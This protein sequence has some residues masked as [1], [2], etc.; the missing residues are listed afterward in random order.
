LVIA[1]GGVKMHELR[2]SEMTLPDY[3]AKGNLVQDWDLTMKHGEV[4]GRAVPIGALM[5]ALSNA[6]L[7]RQVIDRT[8]LTGEYNFDLTWTPEDE[9]DAQPKGDLGLAEGAR[10]SIF[11]AVQ[12][13]LGLRLEPTRA[14]VDAL[15]IEHIERPTN[16]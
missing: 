12:E 11:T 1:K 7:D 10:L 6:S 14:E 5:Y 9:L 2:T 4:H 3:D 16:D 13:Q 8:G 15:V